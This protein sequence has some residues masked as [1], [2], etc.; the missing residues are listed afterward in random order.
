MMLSVEYELNSGF[1][2]KCRLSKDDEVV[3]KLFRILKYLLDLLSYLLL[4]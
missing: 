3:L 4:C 2:M 1:T